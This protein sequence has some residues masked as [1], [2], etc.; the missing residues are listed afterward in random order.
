[1]LRLCEMISIA[2]RQLIAA[3][4]RDWYMLQMM[5]LSGPVAKSMEDRANVA[6][7]VFKALYEVT[8]D[9]D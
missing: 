1:M 5:Q 6:Q 2:E 7:E 9:G 4:I 8:N 3:F